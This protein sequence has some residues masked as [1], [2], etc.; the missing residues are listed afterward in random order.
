MVRYAPSSLPAGFYV[1]VAGAVPQSRISGDEQ[2][3]PQLCPERPEDETVAQQTACSGTR[4]FALVDVGAYLALGQLRF[5]ATGE[6]LTDTQGSWRGAAL[7][8]GGQSV[9]LRVAFLF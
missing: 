9:R 8:T 7:G 2:L 1:R 3:D 6:N 4:G 5:D